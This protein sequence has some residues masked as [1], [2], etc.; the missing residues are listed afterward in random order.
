MEKFAL[1]KNKVVQ[2]ILIT[3][4]MPLWLTVLSYI[5]SFLIQAGRII[6]T[7]IRFV[8]EGGMCLF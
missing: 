4:T 5:F 2:A 1:F 6:G 3:I 8:G 7:F